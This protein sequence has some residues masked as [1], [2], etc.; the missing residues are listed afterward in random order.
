MILFLTHVLLHIDNTEQIK[1]VNNYHRTKKEN[2]SKAE[3]V[4]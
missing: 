4:V 3:P 2:F 1:L